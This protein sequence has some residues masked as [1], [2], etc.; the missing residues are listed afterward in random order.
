MIDSIQFFNPLV[1][2][3]AISIGLLLWITFLWKEWNQPIRKSFFLNAVIAF[4]TIGALAMLVLQPMV[5]DYGDTRVG[6]LLTEGYAKKNLDS[7]RARY[8]NVKTIEYEENVP[9]IAEL[10]SI[11]TVF[12]LGH[13]LQGFDF[14][15][16]EGIPATYAGTVAPVGVVGVNYGNLHSV[17][18]EVVVKVRYNSPE[19]GHQ[20]ILAEPGGKKL[21]SI[22]LQAQG[23]GEVALS[24]ILKAKG[25]YVYHL[26][27]QDSTGNTLMKEPLPIEV[28][29]K[30]ALRILMVN[31]F[32]TFESKYLKNYLAEIGHEVSVRSQLTKGKFKFEYFNTARKPFYDFSRK[33]LQSLDLVIIDANSYRT[34]GKK[35]RQEL[36]DAIKGDGLGVFVLPDK[37]LFGRSGKVSNFAFLRQESTQVR[38]NK[39]PELQYQK[40]PYVFK[41]H[42][43]LE[44]VHR[45]AD[46]PI[47]A[48]QRNGLGRIGTTTVQNSHE[49]V[50][51][52]NGK[53]YK[54]F[55]SE[56]IGK[57]SKRKQ[58]LYKFSVTNSFSYENEAFAFNLRTS[59]K[60]PKVIGP[61]GRI[62]LRQDTDIEELWSGVTYPRKEGWHEINITN[63]TTATFNFYTFKNGHWRSMRAHAAI[64]ENKKA[65]NT[66]MGEIPQKKVPRPIPSFWFYMLFLFGMGYLWLAPKLVRPWL[67]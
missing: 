19:E 52:G 44:I 66:K 67:L 27:A 56:I 23:M 65:F 25:K 21:D 61:N 26:M 16:L 41:A 46:I 36:D 4:L 47:T 32:P 5:L 45:S 9:F 33:R 28:A 62:A 17:G 31:S 42:R 3:P 60:G 29:P 39:I 50:L 13:G 51:K 20:L 54:R 24:A 55:W 15:Q 14:W 38:L 8:S 58:A 63:D 22:P 10:D 59:D 40:Y 11:S 18:E 43:A 48:Y 35:T 57:L 7:I 64:A 53:N 2:W 49:H 37:D 30:K 1:L 6:I 34:L 12:I